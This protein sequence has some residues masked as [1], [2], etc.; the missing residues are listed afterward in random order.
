M[1]IFHIQIV[2]NHPLLVFV[3]RYRFN[4]FWHAVIFAVFG[5]YSHL[6]TA[7]RKSLAVCVAFLYNPVDLIVTVRLF[8]FRLSLR[9]DDFF[10]VTFGLIFRLKLVLMSFDLL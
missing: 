5:N 4:C 10:I 7:L 8:Y 3:F 2:F 6:E 1:E 9:L